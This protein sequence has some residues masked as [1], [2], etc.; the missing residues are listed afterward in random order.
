MARL[1]RRDQPGML[2]HVTNRSLGHIPLFETERDVR[3]FLALLALLVRRGALQV[4]AY[5]VLSTHFH[6][7]VTSGEA[8]L[9]TALQ[10]LQHLYAR[11]FNRTRER[12]GHAFK[13]RYFSRP[14]EDDAYR[15]QV[16]AYIDRNPVV[17]RMAEHPASYPHGSARFY[18]L[19]RGRPWLRRDLVGHLVERITRRSFDPAD[20]HRLWQAAAP[21]G[22]ELV[23]R[24]LQQRTL[25]A[26]P[27]HVL[28]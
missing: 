15:L 12:D 26:A 27:V 21:P 25:V 19:G 22:D 17:A 9:A 3:A 11:W 16:V 14:V 4:H 2:H 1:A 18:V 13:A 10:W 20:Y 23:E 7:L 8:G 24:L 28:T 6:L 5:A